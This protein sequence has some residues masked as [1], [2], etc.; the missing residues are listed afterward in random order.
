M[1]RLTTL[2]RMM[3]PTRVTHPVQVKIKSSVLLVVIRAYTTRS[4]ASEIKSESDVV[5]FVV[6]QLKQMQY[7]FMTVK[8]RFDY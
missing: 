3:T 7:Y 8:Y 4:F 2:T 5:D 6:H 1:N